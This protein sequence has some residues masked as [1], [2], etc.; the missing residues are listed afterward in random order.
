MRVATSCR[1]VKQKCWEGVP[2]GS[3]AASSKCLGVTLVAVL[4]HPPKGTSRK[5][6]DISLFQ[7]RVL[8]VLLKTLN[9]INSHGRTLHLVCLCTI[10]FRFLTLHTL[11][12][13]LLM[14]NA[15]LYS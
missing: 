5:G 4:H 6:S 7:L 2:W 12:A 15:F 14:I 3:I 13:R 9:D 10:V 1:S 11:E 8:N